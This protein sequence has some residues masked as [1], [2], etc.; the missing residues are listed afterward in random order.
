[1]F[2][3]W[4]PELIQFY[5]DAYLPSFGQ[6]KHPLAM[7]QRGEECWP[8]IWPLIHPQIQ[9]VMER[10]IA[11]WHEDQLVPIYRNGRL[12]DVYWTYGYSPVFDEHGAI[13]GTLVVCLETTN[14]VVAQNLIEEAHKKAEAAH[15]RLY[16]LFDAAPAVVCTLTGPDHVFEMVNPLY[17]MLVGQGRALVGLPIAQ[18]LP[19]VVEQGFGEILD[20]VF[21]SGQ[22]FIGNETHVA[23]ARDGRALE[24][25]HVTF[26]YQPRRGVSGE[27]E[28]IDV[29]G[30][31]VSVQVQARKD[32]ERAANANRYFAE[33]IPQQVWS[34]NVQGEIVFVNQRVLD[35]FGVPP[36]Q[37]LGNGWASFV[38]PDD[39]SDAAEKWANALRTGTLYETEFRLR[40]EDGSYRWFLARA[41][42]MTEEG[43][44]VVQWFGTNTDVDENIRLREALRIRVDFE[45][46]LIGIVSHDLRSPL[47]IISLGVNILGARDDLDAV[48][49]KTILRIQS[50]VA[51]SVRLIRDLLDFTDARVGGGLRMKPTTLNMVNLVHD[52][53][54]EVRIVHPSCEFVVKRTCVGDGTW[55]GDRIAQALINLITNAAHYGDC[56]RPITIEVAEHHDD[57]VISVHNYGEPIDAAA[58]LKLFEP[59]QRGRA[60]RDNERR[61]VGLGL[62]IVSEIAR[63]HQGRVEVSSSLEAGTTFTIVLPRHST[64]MGER[65]LTPSLRVSPPNHRNSSVSHSSSRGPTSSRSSSHDSS[66]SNKRPSSPDSDA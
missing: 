6:G 62:Y 5:N 15:A 47:H 43:G 20:Q 26:I 64:S 44:D 56:T 40:H 1:M 8:E 17:Q 21:Q 59:L 24:D 39:W 3:W 4:G 2:L 19:E 37:V 66:S 9:D 53:V 54:D 38:H 58:Q 45:Q 29:F 36:E 12:E 41:V 13:A 63:E 10:G 16:Q 50:A 7:G 33:A 11:S 31:D 49:T 57:I 61:S 35:Y 65:R 18:A 14:E 52:V 55:D 23:L 42:P 27:I 28:G 46:Y 34:A 48:A 25:A 22:A 30:F 60:E 51:R 32:A